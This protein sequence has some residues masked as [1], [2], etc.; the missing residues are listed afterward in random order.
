[1]IFDVLICKSGKDKYFIMHNLSHGAPR[2]G[3]VMPDIGFHTAA[4]GAPNIKV[5]R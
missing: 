5:I 4:S 3:A 2:R 1:M